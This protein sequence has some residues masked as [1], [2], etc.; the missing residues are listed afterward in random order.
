MI[1]FNEPTKLGQEIKFIGDLLKKNYPISSNSFYSKKCINFLKKKLNINYS[2]LTG[3][4]TAALE[5]TALIL[6]VKKG[7]EIILPSFSFVTT[8]NAF[9]L[10]GA[11]LVYADIDK[12]SLNLDLE[13]VEKKITKKTKAVVVVNYAGS[14]CNLKLL[15]KITEKKKIFL[16]ED[17]A[18]SIFSKFQKTPLGTIGDFGCYSF[19]ETKN[20][21]CGQGGALIIKNKKFYNKALHIRDKGTN[22]ATIKPTQKYVW[23]SLGSSYALTETLSAHLYFQLINWKKIIKKRLKIWKIYN[24]FFEKR[25]FKNLLTKNNYKKKD[26]KLGIYNAHIFYLVLNKKYNR[27]KFLKSLQ[28]KGVFCT[29]HYEPLHLSKFSRKYVKKKYKLPNTELITKQLIRLPLHYNMTIKDAKIVCESI[30]Q[31]V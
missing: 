31:F 16:I 3:S 5:M 10:R 1:N 20:I 30:D 2:I 12:L 15:K 21:H 28:D 27:D 24:Q 29:T 6:D 14:S 8:A 23:A 18:Q 22:K 7:D 26:L 4:C 9:A 11:K 19:H 17:A 13:D 25:K